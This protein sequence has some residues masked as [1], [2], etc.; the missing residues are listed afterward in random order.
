[1]SFSVLKEEFGRRRLKIR[2]NKAGDEKRLGGVGTSLHV[3]AHQQEWPCHSLNV[4]IP[5]QT[6][7]TLFSAATSHTAVQAKIN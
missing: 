1:M 5:D 6:A 2:Q 7:L 4:L 3:A